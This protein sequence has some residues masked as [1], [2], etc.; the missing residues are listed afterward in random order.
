[1]FGLLEGWTREETASSS[2]WLLL[3]WQHQ[4]SQVQCT[5]RI[6]WMLMRHILLS[7]SLCF[8][9]WPRQTVAAHNVVFALTSAADVS[10]AIATAAARTED[11]R[12]QP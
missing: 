10:V 12:R 3:C 8:Y 1:V 5:I 2:F 11:D 6:G 9:H 4:P 7:E